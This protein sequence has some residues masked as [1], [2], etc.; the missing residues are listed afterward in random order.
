MDMGV[1]WYRKLFDEEIAAMVEYHRNMQYESAGKEEYSAAEQYKE[2][3]DKW[4]SFA[5]KG[6]K[7]VEEA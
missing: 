1:K 5:G 3:A 7:I 4:A 6:I 2:R